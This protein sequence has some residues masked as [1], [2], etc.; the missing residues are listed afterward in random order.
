MSYTI[1]YD[2][3]FL[4]LED[5]R[6]I[7][8]ILCGSN[9]CRETSYSG[10]ERRERYWTVCWERNVPAYQPEDLMKL[11]ESYCSGGEYQEHFMRG[12]KWVDD[13][14]Y[15]RFFKNGIK[16]AKTLRELDDERIHASAIRA[17]F[18]IWATVPGEKEGKSGHTTECDRCLR[19][20]EEIVAFLNEADERLKRETAD[21]SVYIC[22]KY[23]GNDPLPKVKR[24]RKRKERLTGEFYVIT[25]DTDRYVT[26]LTRGG[27]YHYPHLNAA[28]QFRTAQEAEKW[29][30]QRDLT[31]RFGKEL[32]VKKAS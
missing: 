28:K 26:K 2:R 16:Q 24:E 30:E 13:A 5:G 25:L 10:R 20:D 23:F 9:N 27:L 18:S 1:V 3:Q 7:P 31:V 19:S 17:F 4:K 8:M 12:G 14:A 6:I 15:L 29:I 32:K 22:L 21:E 11:A